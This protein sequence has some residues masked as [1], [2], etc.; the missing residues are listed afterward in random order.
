MENSLIRS[1]STSRSDSGLAFSASS[2]CTPLLA[3]FSIFRTVEDESDDMDVSEDENHSMD[4]SE[5]EELSEIFNQSERSAGPATHRLETEAPFNE[6]FFEDLNLES[7][8]NSKEEE[9]RHGQAGFLPLPGSRKTNHMP[10][11]TPRRKRSAE[12]DQTFFGNP[13]KMRRTSY[14]PS[15]LELSHNP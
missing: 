6:L 15:V 4:I 13:N 12:T 1:T 10:E 8:D 3:A 2:R 11:S 9:L 5:D 14:E 7:E